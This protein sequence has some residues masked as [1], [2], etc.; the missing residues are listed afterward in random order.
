MELENNDRI[1]VTEELVMESKKVIIT[2]QSM[3]VEKNEKK[4]SKQVIEHPILI[5]GSNNVVGNN[6][7]LFNSN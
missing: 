6:I 3:T 1:F 7:F 4:E 2:R 5:V